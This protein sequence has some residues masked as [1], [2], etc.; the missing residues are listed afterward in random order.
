MTKKEKKK[1]KVNGRQFMYLAEREREREHTEQTDA[2]KKNKTTKQKK[3]VEFYVNKD[4]S[5]NRQYFRTREDEKKPK[6]MDFDAWLDNSIAVYLP[7]KTVYLIALIRRFWDFRTRHFRVFY[8]IVRFSRMRE[9]RLYMPLIKFSVIF[10]LSFKWSMELQ[11]K[12]TCF[13]SFI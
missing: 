6:L 11:I 10:F 2:K 4:V 9:L 7:N 5:L 3:M 8:F 1:L 12:S 13:A